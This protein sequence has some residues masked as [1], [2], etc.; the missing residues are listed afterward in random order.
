MDLGI[1]GKTAFVAASSSGMGLAAAR[2]LA[3]EGVNVVLTGRRKEL[4]REEAE[5]IAADFGV[6]AL[7]VR[8]DIVDE[9]GLE[10]ALQRAEDEFGPADIAV[11]NGPGP[12]PGGSESISA[13]EID[14][15]ASVMITPHVTIVNNLLPEMKRRGWGRIVA[16]GSFT[17]NR[18]S[19]TLSLSA[20][21]RAGLQRYLEGLAREVAGFG[22][23]VNIVQPGLIDT[24][25]IGALDQLEAK[26]TGMPA[27]KVRE[28]R[29]SSIPYGRLGTP[30]EFAAAVTFLASDPARYIT[31]QS[32]LVDGGLYAAG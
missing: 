18:A 10:A 26:N 29:E 32:L 13:E 8:C 1:A 30:D 3:R 11:L 5:K 9:R 19:T 25:R 31:G 23:T 6:R 14:R 4:L 27:S 12:R 7:P 15:A 24:D 20:I 28:N 21:G 16:V 2:S 17:M 22:V